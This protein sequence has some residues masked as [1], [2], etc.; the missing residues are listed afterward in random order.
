LVGLVLHVCDDTP[1]NSVPIQGHNN[2]TTLSQIPTGHM[3]VVPAHRQSDDMT[4]ALPP[5]KWPVELV[6]ISKEAGREKY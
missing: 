3:R 2:M 5:D 6:L 1:W 4:V